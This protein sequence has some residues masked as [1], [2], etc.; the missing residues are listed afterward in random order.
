MS[1][2]SSITSIDVYRKSSS[3]EFSG[4]EIASSTQQFAIRVERNSLGGSDGANTLGTA[5]LYRSLDSQDGTLIQ[6]IRLIHECIENL[7]SA[8]RIDSNLDFIGYDE[9]VMRLK[10]LLRKLFMLRSIGDGFG[11][12][13]SAIIWGLKNQEPEAL[14]RPQISVI[15]DVLGQLRKKPMLH[16]DSSMNLLDHLEDA[17][18]NIEPP[19]VGL[20]SEIGE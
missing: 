7:H 17:G 6:A 3:T 2:T 14:A 5:E 20:L 16:F 18:L 1:A 11:S 10:D 19:I 9:K 12:V 8:E 4:S 15:L 13:V